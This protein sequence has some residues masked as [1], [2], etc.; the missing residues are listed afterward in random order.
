[1]EL[2]PNGNTAVCVVNEAGA[3]KVFSLDLKTK[4]SAEIRGLPQGVHL[5]GSWHPTLPEVA[6]TINSAKSTSDVY[7]VNLETGKV[8]RWTE[9]ELGGITPDQLSEPKLIQWESFDGLNIS[10]FYYAPPKS[11]AGSDRSS[12]TFTADLKVRRGHFS[13]KEQLLLE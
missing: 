10:G 12:S 8:D 1:M 13:G 2:S 5:V 4:K 3:S 11:F 9:S 6:F 7:S